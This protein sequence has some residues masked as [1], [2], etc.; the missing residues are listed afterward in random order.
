MQICWRRELSCKGGPSGAAREIYSL[1][2][3]DGDGES[4]MASVASRS[5]PSP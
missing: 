2:E 4:M 5:A 1:V 3:A